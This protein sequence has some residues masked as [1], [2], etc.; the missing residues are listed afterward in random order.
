MSTTLLSP[1]ATE[2]PRLPLDHLPGVWR[3]DAWSD[4]DRPCTP[5]GHAPLDAALPGGGWPQ[6][7]LIDLLQPASEHTEWRLLL[8]ALVASASQGPLLLVG[9]PHWP[10]LH[11]LAAHGLPSSR[12]CLVSPATAA[13]RL[14]CAEQ[15]LRCPDVSAIVAWLPEA[16][17]DALRRLHLAAQ[18]ARLCPPCA[19]HQAPLL[20]AWRSTEV[21]Q[22][23][24][25]SP[26]RMEVRS[27]GFHGLQVDVFKRRG[28]PL[29]APLHLDAR[30]P[31]HRLMPR[32]ARDRL[33]NPEWT[34]V[35]DRPH[36]RA[37]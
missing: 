13:D 31:V 11:A 20:F 8:P 9:A 4:P 5:T 33:P 26:L 6:G 25:P 32:W 18:Q 37:A 19:T 34:H 10:N 23:H 2:R 3:G 24:A 30:L 35:V 14:W 36:A 15:A 27:M 7:Q 12:L 1:F 21:R 28:P 22:D 16:R 29:A 17:A